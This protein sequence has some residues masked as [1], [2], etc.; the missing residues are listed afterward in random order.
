MSNPFAAIETALAAVPLAAVSNANLVWVAVTIAGVFD[1]VYADTL[2]MSNSAPNF[3]C[4]SASVAAMAQGA[5]VSV[6]KNGATTAYTVREIQPDGNGL[7][8]LVLEAA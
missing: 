3:V 6:V 8:R 2:G 5:A 1:N 4:G 7:T